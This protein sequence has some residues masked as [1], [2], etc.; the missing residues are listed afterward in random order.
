MELTFLVSRDGRNLKR[1]QSR[2][3]CA[4]C[5][6]RKKRC[7]HNDSKLQAPIQNQLLNVSDTVDDPGVTRDGV[8]HHLATTGTAT[9]PRDEPQHTPLIEEA[10]EQISNHTGSPDVPDSA[11]TEDE[12]IEDSSSRQFACDSNPVVNLLGEEGSR[13]ERGR[14]RRRDVGGW[15]RYEDLNSRRGEPGDSYEPTQSQ[16]PGLRNVGLVPP[17]DDQEALMDIYFRRIHPILPFLDEKAIR[18]Q[19]ETDALSPRLIQSICLV[20]SK[21]RSAASLLRL[22]QDLAVLT[23]EK[24]SNILYQDITQSMTRK[25]ERKKV[26][27][28]QILTLL[29]LHEWR[30]TGFEDCSLHLMQA[31]HHAQT[32]GLHLL[33]PD[34]QQSSLSLKALFWCL[35][36]LDRW[37]A[38]M[39]GRP[40]MIHDPDIGQ[41]VDDVLP[42]F[43]PPF[44]SWLRL[45]DRLNVVIRFYRPIMDG[46][47][48]Q[49]LD[50]PSFEELVDSS[51]A[52]DTP[53]DFLETLEILNHGVII[54]STYSKRLQGRSRPRMATI[55]QSHSIFTIAS[56]LRNR[57]M[58]DCLPVPMVAYVLSL[59]FSIT[60]GQMKEENLPSARQI[61]KEHLHLFHQCLKS[62]GSTWWSASIITRL[63]NR[64]L[65]DTQHA[66]KLGRSVD[67]TQLNPR[68]MSTRSTSSQTTSNVHHRSHSS[69]G[70]PRALKERGGTCIDVYSDDRRQL[71]SDLST[72]MYDPFDSIDMMGSNIEDFD[73]FFNDFPDINVLRSVGD[74]S[75]LDFEMLDS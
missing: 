41:R 55:R 4:C 3:A 33:R 12:G 60:Y 27:A 16:S 36:S 1:R 58:H 22:G 56:L 46:P 54:L 5:R 11:A 29:S 70:P 31:I 7:F 42:L 34:D 51:N 73:A 13:L 25:V 32:I 9:V 71:E 49:E 64:V 17:K 53:Q 8:G 44:R 30:P 59:T 43:D 28:I 18:A 52:W 57:N 47:E 10:D 23:V 48:E 63:G 62:L 74:Q 14:S 19:F 21:D 61:A 72:N 24:F 40:V 2:G 26:T 66:S 38:A 69:I 68:D 20:A 45:A 35:W 75:F 39:N 50:I 6:R 15:F 67:Q 65:N 37:N